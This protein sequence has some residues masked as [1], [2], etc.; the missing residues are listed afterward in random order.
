M[1]AQ[2]R[3]LLLLK[4][5]PGF[6]LWGT[7]PLTFRLNPPTHSMRAHTP[8]S[9]HRP[10]NT[11]LVWSMSTSSPSVIGQRWSCDPRLANKLRLWDFRCS[12]QPTFTSGPSL[13]LLTW[14]AA[15]AFPSDPRTGHK[16]ATSG[17]HPYPSLHSCLAPPRVVFWLI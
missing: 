7:S 14:A 12:L 15:L 13:V 8:P 2:H 9:K 3:F 10:R 6:P 4:I 17:A 5:A 11:G 1:S 16:P